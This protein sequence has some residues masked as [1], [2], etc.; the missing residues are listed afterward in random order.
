MCVFLSLPTLTL[1]SP[2][3]R[4]PSSPKS[5]DS[6]TVTL[7]HDTAAYNTATG[8]SVLL[9]S[10]VPLT[11][12][13]SRHLNSPPSWHVSPHSSPFSSSVCSN[14]ALCRWPGCISSSLF[15]LRVYVQA[16]YV[17]HVRRHCPRLSLHLHALFFCC[18]FCVCTAQAGKV[19]P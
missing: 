4:K 17:L 5:D 18:F 10:C 3:L 11:V 6:L 19:R 14:T 9:F 15:P 2:F 7:T 8:S 1:F 12:L 13:I 16:H